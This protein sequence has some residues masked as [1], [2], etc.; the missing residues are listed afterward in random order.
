VVK[1]VQN[2][3]ELFDQL[4]VQGAERKGLRRDAP[5]LLRE[6]ALGGEPVP[7]I[8]GAFKGGHGR[9]ANVA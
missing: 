4:G 6:E 2:E 1:A 8:M 5:P 9:E 7:H 3:A